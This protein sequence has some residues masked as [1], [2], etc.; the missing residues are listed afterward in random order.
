MACHDEF[1]LTDWHPI[2]TLE[3][4]QIGQEQTTTLMECAIT[5]RPGSDGNWT[6]ARVGSDTDLPV[7]ERY[8]CLWTCLGVPKGEVIDIPEARDSERFLVSGG[9]I[10]VRTSG[11]RVVEN[12]I[13][14]GHFPFVHDGWLGE[15][16]HTEVIPYK[17]VITED[18]EVL[19]TDAQFFQ[20]IASPSAKG[21]ID[22][23]Y[24]YRIFRPYIVGLYKTNPALGD[25]K[26][27]IVLFI[28]PVNQEECIVHNLL[29]YFKEDMDE[30]TLR[31]FMQVIFG[32]D[33]PILE[34]QTPK[35][36]PLEPRAETPIRADQMSII[37]RRWLQDHAVTYGAI[38]A[39]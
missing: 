5:I 2:A 32:Q 6:A 31:W 11:L 19:A 7:R 34:N 3:Q 33:K 24:M 16:P 36:L 38:P 22:V 13:D 23:H 12:F 10:G 39:A 35:R 20:P 18:D 17:V 14:M 30:V 25:Q 1:L 29:C 15:Q 28:Q 26:D 37:Y 4:L 9:A 8:G 27:F 21:G